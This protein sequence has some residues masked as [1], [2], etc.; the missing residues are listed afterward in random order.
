M[1]IYVAGA[2]GVIGSRLV[3][4]LVEGGH[5]VTAAT[6]TPDKAAALERLGA[7]AVVVDG[8][9]GAAVG[10][11]V[12]EAAPDAITHQMSALGGRP[13]PKHFDRWFRVT[14]R[15]RTE[16]THHLLAAAQACGV[17][18]VVAQ[19][20]TGWPNIRTGGW[21]KTEDDPLDPDPPKHQRE[22]LA[23]IEHLETVV[24]K[25]GGAV[26]RYGGF[27][28]PGASDALVSLV[29]RRR[30]PIIGH[31]TGYMSWVHADDAAAATVLALEQR[32]RGVYNVV[33]DEPAPVSEWLPHLARCIGAKP[34]L[35]VP[36]WLGRAAAGEVGVTT[37]TDS[38]GSS[39]ARARR[40]LVWQPRWP[41]WRV[42]F[43]EALVEE[44]G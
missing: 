22:T 16:G 17:D 20:Y 24:A 31:G 32:A 28:G 11:A 13:D 18:H 5:Q 2:T 33:D 19:S 34:P 30:F 39:N 25:A 6:R 8:L 40:D 27:Y 9:D 42:G 12:A 21:V 10:Q 29:R 15:L 26:L 3:P 14:N 41:T 23:A 36:V 7:R 37:M 35:R 44:P 43:R 38:R 4:L 1:R